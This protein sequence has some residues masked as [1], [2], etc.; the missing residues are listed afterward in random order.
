MSGH[1]RRA[2][3]GSPGAGLREEEDWQLGGQPGSIGECH[4]A[5]GV[6][7]EQPPMEG[8]RGRYTAGLRRGAGLRSGLAFALSL[9]SMSLRFSFSARQ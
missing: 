9:Q 5:W 1:S 2:R 8:A 7:T 3:E 4:S 6:G